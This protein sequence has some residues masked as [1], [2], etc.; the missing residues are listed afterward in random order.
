MVGSP[1]DRSGEPRSG[2]VGS[3]QV[4]Q[5]LYGTFHFYGGTWLAA[6]WLG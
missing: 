1:L 3:G 6:A 2:E 5:G 4:R